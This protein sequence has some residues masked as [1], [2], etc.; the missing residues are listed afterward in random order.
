M[1]NRQQSVM[2]CWTAARAGIAGIGL[3]AGIAT[4]TA[5]ARAQDFTHDGYTAD[6]AYTLNVE[7]TPYA[8]LPHVATTVNGI[9]PRGRGGVSGSI[10]GWQI[11]HSLRGAFFGD[12]LV[13]YGPYS[14]EINIDWVDLGGSKDIALPR[15][16]QS[17][18]LDA[19]GSMVLVS[20]GVGY[21]IYRG[22]VAS[23][24]L[25][26]DARVGFQ[27]MSWSVSASTA[28]DL[29][30]GASGSG[31]KASPWLG[32]RTDL[33]PMPNLRVR[34]AG[35]LTGFGTN[36]GSWGWTT[37]LTLTYLF[38]D[39]FDASIGISALQASASADRTDIFGTHRSTLH[40]IAY[41]PL[42]GVGF[43]F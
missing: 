6:G 41:G 28:D 13:R 35:N 39:W 20:P 2:T 11:V 10:S 40:A 9:G 18:H 16:G 12:G 22:Q 30:G 7:L 37:T 32:I 17:A 23:A 25:T 43:R 26:V 38:N 8:F 31:D 29:L 5:S 15:L 1:V 24:P 34:F 4:C 14:A 27:Y 42:I 19:S 33:F 21:Q 36:N 3:A